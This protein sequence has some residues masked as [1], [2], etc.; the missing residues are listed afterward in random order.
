MRLTEYTDKVLEYLEYLNYPE[1][2][3]YFEPGQVGQAIGNATFEMH[4]ENQSIRMCALVIFGATWT[5]Q[6]AKVDGQ[7]IQ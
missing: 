6:I 2:V 1:Y 4:K 7:T 5:Y 3:E